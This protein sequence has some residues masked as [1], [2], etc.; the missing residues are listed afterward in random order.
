MYRAAQNIL[1]KIMK[2][3]SKFYKLAIS[4]MV[5]VSKCGGGP[6]KHCGSQ[7]HNQFGEDLWD[8]WVQP[9]AEH[10]HI[11]Y[12]MELSAMS[13]LSSNTSRES[14]SPTSLGSPIQYLITF[15]IKILPIKNS[16]QRI[17][18]EAINKKN[19]KTGKTYRSF[20]WSSPDEKLSW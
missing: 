17:L 9:V 14:D 11:N 18:T 1:W 2:D 19:Q 20:K 15:S 12:T 8:H 4:S 6:L 10:Q 3:F 7:N 5:S 13:N 16:M